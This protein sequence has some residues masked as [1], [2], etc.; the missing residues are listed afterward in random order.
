MGADRITQV[1]IRLAKGDCANRCQRRGEKLNLGFGIK[2][3]HALFGQV[4]VERCQALVSQRRVQCLERVNS[5]HQY[6][7]IHRI[8]VGH[9]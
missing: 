4:V 3:L 2:L 9:L 5:G 6:R 1:H 8:G 7:L